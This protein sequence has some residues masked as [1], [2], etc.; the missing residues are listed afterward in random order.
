MSLYATMDRA[1]WMESHNRALREQACAWRTAEKRPR[2]LNFMTLEQAMK[3]IES[4]DAALRAAL[5]PLRNGAYKD[6]IA[7]VEAALKQPTRK[8]RKVTITVEL[9]EWFAKDFRGGGFPCS[10]TLTAYN[11]NVEVNLYVETRNVVESTEE[12]PL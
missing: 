2:G 5:R 8:V 7:I 9:P 11:G 6:E 12:I 4:K 10:Y 3:Q 1:G